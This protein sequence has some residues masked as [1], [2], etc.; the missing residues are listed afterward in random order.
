MWVL[1]VSDAA[2][3][4]EELDEA[5]GEAEAGEGEADK[6]RAFEPDIEFAAPPG[7]QDREHGEGDNEGGGLE[8]LTEK[9]RINQ[10]FAQTCRKT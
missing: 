2:E 10:W 7:A 5:G 4:A 6:R 8:R 9:D 1:F 3:A